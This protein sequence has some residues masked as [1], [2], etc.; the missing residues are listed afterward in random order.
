MQPQVALRRH[1]P[2]HASGRISV[3]AGL[4]SVKV[5][6]P[7]DL[8]PL[9]GITLTARA[10]DV[11]LLVTPDLETLDE[12]LNRGDDRTHNTPLGKGRLASARYIRTRYMATHGASVFQIVG[13]SFHD[14]EHHCGTKRH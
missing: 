1:L 14:T 13:T 5:A 11:L 12:T 2:Q 7:G 8:Q 6:G 4:P 9:G 3:K 10:G